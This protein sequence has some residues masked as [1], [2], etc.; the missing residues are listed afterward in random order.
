[1]RGRIVKKQNCML[2]EISIFEKSSNLKIGTIK[3]KMC[4]IVLKKFIVHTSVTKCLKNHSLKISSHPR[5]FIAPV[6][7]RIVEI[8]KAPGLF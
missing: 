5:A 6:D 7:Y 1:M 4:R 3:F 2:R 8:F